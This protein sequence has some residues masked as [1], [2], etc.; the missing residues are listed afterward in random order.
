VHLLYNESAA[1][2]VDFYYVITSAE[3]RGRNLAN[4]AGAL[5]GVE[6]FNSS[7]KSVRSLEIMYNLAFISLR[8]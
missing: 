7:T 4:Q 3:G 5:T 8:M 6:Q 1:H 2:T